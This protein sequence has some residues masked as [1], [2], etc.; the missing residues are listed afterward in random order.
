MKR[1]ETQLEIGLF[2]IAKEEVCS[3]WL[4]WQEFDKGPGVFFLPDDVYLGIRAQWIDDDQIMQLV[5][6]F[7]SVP[8][9]LYLYLAENRRITNRGMNALAD[10]RQ[11]RYLNI[12]ACDITSDG[13]AFMPSLPNLEHLDMSYCNR[14]TDEAAKYFKNSRKLKYLDVQGVPKINSG[15]RKKFEHSGLTIHHKV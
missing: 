10:L 6:E 8:E 15:G 14:I 11:L 7:S 9:L 3:R 5:Q 4:N 1:I 2:T 13:M 12:S